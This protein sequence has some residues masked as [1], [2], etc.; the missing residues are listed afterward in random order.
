MKQKK[1]CLLIDDDSDD[2]EIFVLALEHINKDFVCVVAS[3]GHEALGKLT[4]ANSPL[5]DYIFLDLNMPRMNGKECLKEIKKN[6]LLNHI[7]VII[8]TTS[9]MASDKSETASL[10]ASGFI[11]KPFSLPELIDLLLIFFGKE[12]E[13]F[14]EQY[15]PLA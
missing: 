9:S 8:Y 4:T 11:T 12:R 5:P 14:Y 2:Q 13:S 7:P 3:N 10:G 1:I 15:V 6:T